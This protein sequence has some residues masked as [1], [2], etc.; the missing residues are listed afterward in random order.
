MANNVNDWEVDN[1][2]LKSPSQTNN[3]KKTN[4]I[5]VSETNNDW[6]EIYVCIEKFAVGGLN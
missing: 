6:H 2:D 4:E 1:L 5:K 3:W